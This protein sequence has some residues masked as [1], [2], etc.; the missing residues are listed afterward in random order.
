MTR[1]IPRYGLVPKSAAFSLT[2]RDSLREGLFRSIGPF[3]LKS[4]SSKDKAHIFGM[5]KVIGTSITTLR[6]LR[7]FWGTMILMLMKRLGKY[8]SMVLACSAPAATEFEGQLAKLICSNI[9]WVESVQFLNSGSEATS[10]A[11]RLARAATGR[12]HIVGSREVTTV[13]A[14]MSPS[15]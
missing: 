9:P 15:I 6:S 8:F 7:T 5:R 4:S 14:M 13:G 10:Q 1:Y 3:N 11:L 2:T 12:S